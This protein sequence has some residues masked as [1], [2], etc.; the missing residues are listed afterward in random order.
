[1]NFEHP[2]LSK[3]IPK[4]IKITKE[5]YF[6]KFECKKCQK[7]YHELIVA[8]GKDCVRGQKIYDDLFF[9]IYY[10]ILPNSLSNTFAYHEDIN[11][12]R[13][14]FELYDVR[15]G[16]IPVLTKI[17]YEIGMV[18]LIDLCT[19]HSLWL[20][21]FYHQMSKNNSCFMFEWDEMHQSDHVKSKNCLNF[22]IYLLITC[23][24]R[25]ALIQEIRDF[26]LF[27]PVVE[28]AICGYEYRQSKLNFESMK[29]KE[30]QNQ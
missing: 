11:V 4:N 7:Y 3:W 24:K 10:W 8:L 21:H 22:L 13:I 17:A 18:N 29:R 6:Q 27:P 25:K 26:S 9:D 20:H 5:E 19:Y 30:V 2:K 23:E 16:A 12:L 14:A 28:N 1:M 15:Y